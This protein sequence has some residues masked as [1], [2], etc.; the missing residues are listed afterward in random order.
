MP[1]Y[2]TTINPH[3]FHKEVSDEVLPSLSVDVQT[4]MLCELDHSKKALGSLAGIVFI[5]ERAANP[6]C[7]NGDKQHNLS[8]IDF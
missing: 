7:R 1:E 3:I 5:V 8:Q 4:M 2:D 6:F